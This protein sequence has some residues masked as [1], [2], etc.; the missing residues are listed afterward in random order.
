MSVDDRAAIRTRVA[1]EMFTV[2]FGR[3]PL[4]AREIAGFIARQSRP[5]ATTVA[6]FDLTFSPPKS[7]ST[8]WA[9]ANRGVAA[10]IETAHREAV[11]IALRFVEQSLLFTREGTNGARQ[12]DVTGLVGAA[13][14]HRDTRA[15]DPDLHT[16]VAVANK[17]KAVES[18]KWLAIDGRVLYQGIVVASE[19]YNTALVKLLEAQ[20]LAFEDRY[21]GVR[22]RGRPVREISGVAAELNE[23]WSTRRAEIEAYRAQLVAGFQRDHGR[24]P[25]VVES[26]KLAQLATLATRDVKHE[27]R[28][29]LE[30]RIEWHRQALEVLGGEKSLRRMMASVLAPSRRTL[31]RADA[32]WFEQ[33]A[34]RILAAVQERG[35]TWQ[36]VHLRAEAQRQVRRSDIRIDQI[37]PAVDWLVGMAKDRSVSLA[38]PDHG[39]ID[40]PAL[41]RKDGAS[42]YT[43]A[44]AE[45]FTSRA[46]LEAE[47]RLVDLAGTNGARIAAPGNVARTIAASAT[48]GREL[49][50]GQSFLVTAMA[51]SGARLQL[52]IA[53]AGAGKTTAMQALT[54]AWMIDGGNVIGLAPSAAAAEVLADVVGIATENTAKWLSEASRNMVRSAEIDK[55][56]AEL[57]RASPSLRTRTLLHRARTLTDEMGRWALRPGQLVI[58]DEASMAGTFELDALTAQARDAGAKVL[59]VGDWAQLSRSVPVGHSTCSPPTATT[60]HSCR[61]SAGSATNG[62]APPRSTCATAAPTPPTPTPN[63]AA[64]RAGTGSRCSTCSTRRG[65]STPA[66]G[67]AR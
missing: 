1:R 10:R 14:T 42:V 33:A 29:L 60:S 21:T 19:T 3:A 61:T 45:Q 16:H 36:D 62:N 58:V 17:V 66:P 40:P 22:D 6:G 67:D 32:A 24:P 63:T 37:Q 25:T 54:S 13:F 43:V 52:A 7:V 31:E 46:V 26:V 64:S 35:A 48:E 55:L 30:Q 53:P 59:L 11:M 50:S 15:G 2:E 9:V 4:D 28:T 51:T 41:R 23:R 34:D 12:V 38:R 20:G 5:A 8:L 18:G 65:R 44:C 49:T 47:K 57:Y 27:P 56:Q 39:I